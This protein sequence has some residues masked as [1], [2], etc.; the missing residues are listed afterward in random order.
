[1]VMEWVLYESH[2]CFAKKAMREVRVLQAQ[3]QGLGKE[4]GVRSVWYYERRGL[5][6]SGN[7]D[8]T[9]AVKL[10]TSIVFADPGDA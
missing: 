3:R 6:P 1:M 8:K 2:F 5:S 9:H 7:R 4:E 10:A